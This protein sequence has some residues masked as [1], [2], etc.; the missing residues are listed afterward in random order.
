MSFGQL[1]FCE[2]AD[3]FTALQYLSRTASGYLYHVRLVLCVPA[4][5]LTGKEI[6]RKGKEGKVLVVL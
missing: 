2:C 6:R 1:L 5:C 4:D 3:F